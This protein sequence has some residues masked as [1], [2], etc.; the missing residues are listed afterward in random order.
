MAQTFPF[1]G[2][3]AIAINVNFVYTYT[4]I[5]IYYCGRKYEKR[6]KKNYVR[7]QGNYDIL[8]V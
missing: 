7:V 4:Y 3:D 6:K 8:N 5:Y 2:G 1:E